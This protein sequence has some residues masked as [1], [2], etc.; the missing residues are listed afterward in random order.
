MEFLRVTRTRR[1]R[2][3]GVSTELGKAPPPKGGISAA[4]ETGY[5]KQ[6]VWVL[7]TPQDSHSE[8]WRLE[9]ILFLPEIPHTRT[10]TP[11]SV[12]FVSRQNKHVRLFREKGAPVGVCST[13][14]GFISKNLRSPSSS[15]KIKA[16]LLWLPTKSSLQ[17]L[18][19]ARRWG[20]AQNR[21][22]SVWPPSR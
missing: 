15:P 11:G 12:D 18:P 4:Q 5:G 16:S 13:R 17:V 10:H 3:S 6:R 20:C 14:V 1:N 8:F 22:E 2:R 9:S 21:G 7:T 19:R